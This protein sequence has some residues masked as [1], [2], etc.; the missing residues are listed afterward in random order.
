MSQILVLQGFFCANLLINNKLNI[1]NMKEQIK[2]I[3][4]TIK[5]QNTRT[6]IISV[7]IFLIVIISTIYYFSKSMNTN[8]ETVMDSSE[9]VSLEDEIVSIVGD[10]SFLTD[11]NSMNNSWSAEIISND[12][13]QIQPQREGVIVDWRVYVGQRVSQGQILGKISAPPAT[14]ELIK[15]LSEQ[16][17]SLTRAKAE[18]GVTDEYIKKEQARLDALKESLNSSSSTNS[19]QTFTAL[20]RL[21]E[22]VVVRRNAL[23]TLIERTL[24]NHVAMVTNFFSWKL[25][26]YGG[27]VSWKYGTLNTDIRNSYE[28]S[29]INLVNKMKNGIDLPIEDIQKYLDIAVQLAN[30]TTD[31]TEGFKAMAKAD[32]KEFFDML[33]DYKMAQSEVSDKETEY[34]L[35]ISEKS[36]MLERDKLMALSNITAT[37]ASYSTVYNEIKGEAYMRS[38][39]SGTISAIYKK[40]GDLVGPEM[41]IAVVSGGNKSSLI[42]RVRIP[43]NI[44][45]PKVG[46][47]LTAIRPG[48]PKDTRDVKIVGIGSS[49]DDTG[50]YMADAIFIGDIDWPI[51]S[52]IRVIASTTSTSPIIKYSS[53]VWGDKGEPFVWA[54]SSVGRIY[55]KQI[56]IGRI[57]GTSVEIYEGLK[58]GDKYISSPN[59]D[60][61]EDMLLEEIMKTAG[62]N[63]ESSSDTSNGKGGMFEMEM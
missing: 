26:T 55:K 56:N 40:V 46:E 43:N 61:K 49:L 7:S 11:K 34:K 39:R 60:I 30:N 41:A 29:L 4:M 31:D 3:I 36:S 35:M 22:N 21:N 8:A 28:I 14:P 63:S 52:S 59:A 23:R 48:F 15:M 18:A 5:L 2:K 54:V 62:V 42:A 25:A 12:I 33:S 20:E 53:I 45:K 38:P 32:Q 44:Q 50:S 1:K 9:T 24:A 19:N 17:E 13:S 10:N 16:T 57:L 37:E 58:N 6:I 27:I 51:Q 47:I